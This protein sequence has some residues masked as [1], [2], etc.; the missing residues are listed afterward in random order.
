MKPLGGEKSRV[1]NYKILS[2]C[3]HRFY[4]SVSFICVYVCVCIR[5]RT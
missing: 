3:L 4:I 1:N 2:A 5:D